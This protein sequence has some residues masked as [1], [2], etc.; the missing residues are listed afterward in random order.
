MIDK[1]LA[2]LVQLKDA[3]TN[4]KK[5]HA[6]AEVAVELTKSYSVGEVSAAEYTEL[7]EDIKVSKAIVTEVED[8]KL[9]QDLMEAVS[10][11]IKLVRILSRL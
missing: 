9:Q 3:E 5:L 1:I 8:I 10:K 4:N 2:Q 7:M 11:A 6:L